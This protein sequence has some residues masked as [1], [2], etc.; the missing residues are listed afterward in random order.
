MIL[1]AHQTAFLPWLGYFHKLYNCDVFVHLDTVQF[2]TDDFQQRNY[3]RGMKGQDKKQMLTVPVLTKGRSEQQIRDVEINPNERKWKKKH[4]ETI[5]SVYGK[6]PQFDEVFPAIQEIYSR[7]HAK[8]TDVNRDLT[9]YFADRLGIE[10]KHYYLEGMDVP[11]VSGNPLVDCCIAFGCDTFLFGESGQ[12]YADIDVFRRNHIK[13]YFQNYKHPEYPQHNTDEFISHLSI[14]DLLMNVAG[15]DARMILLD[16]KI[17][18][19][20]LINFVEAK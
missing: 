11:E 13:V 5:R 4:L 10:R 19:S 2:N 7:P 18:K 20:E 12:N 8:L 14:L 6:H 9:Q 1:T 17:N 3:I 16:R 15:P